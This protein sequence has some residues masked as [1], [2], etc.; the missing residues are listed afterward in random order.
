[1]LPQIL[2][3][4]VLVFWLSRSCPLTWQFFCAFRSTRP[5]IPLL[6]L[7]LA[8]SILRK[9]RHFGYGLFDKLWSSPFFFSFFF[10]MLTYGGRGAAL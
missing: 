9:N 3:F 6:N 8:R 1:V 7:P 4:L 5:L 2:F 10:F